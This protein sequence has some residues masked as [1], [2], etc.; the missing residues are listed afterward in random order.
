M[1]V[2]VGAVI[3][4]MV[5]GGLTAVFVNV[6]R[7]VLHANR[8]LVATNL[9]RESLNSLYRDVRADTWNAGNLRVGVL[10]HPV[11]DAIID[12]SNYIGNVYTV[13]AGPGNSQYRQV[14]VSINYQ[15][16]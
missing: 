16:D 3:I 6:R 14:T 15:A 11:N 10:P 2:I 8:R 9:G 12:N 1:E 5:F 13:T 7:Y 4:A